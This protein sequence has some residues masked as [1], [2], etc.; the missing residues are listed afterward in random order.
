MGFSEIYLCKQ[1][2]ESNRS[3]IVCWAMAGE[4][5]RI[6]EYLSRCGESC[7]ATYSSKTH[8]LLDADYEIYDHNGVSIRL[9]TLG[10]TVSG[11]VDDETVYSC[12]LP[13]EVAEA[14]FLLAD[15]YWQE[16]RKYLEK[17]AEDGTHTRKLMLRCV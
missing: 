7:Y 17:E 16:E 3:I 10:C 1:L 9:E 5:K 14:L 2:C 13:D 12:T 11:Y 6:E 8:A 4:W 15:K